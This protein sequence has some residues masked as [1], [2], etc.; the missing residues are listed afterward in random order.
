MNWKRQQSGRWLPER[1]AAPQS[2]FMRR[3]K[4]RSL[5]SSSGFSPG[6][7]G[8]SR[9]SPGFLSQGFLS[10]VSCPQVSCPQGF[11]SPGFLSPGFP[12]FRSNG[13]FFDRIGGTALCHRF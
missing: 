12:G 8:T 9:L 2:W 10:Q 5:L 6:V 4:V 7:G 3:G 1:E 13:V 11:L